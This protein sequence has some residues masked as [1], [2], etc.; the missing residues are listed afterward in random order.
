MKKVIFI[1]R[2]FLQFLIFES[3]HGG[4]E[5]KMNVEVDVMQ[6]LKSP[7]GSLLSPEVL[8]KRFQSRN[9]LRK[10]KKKRTNWM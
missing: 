8:I 3:K 2:R 10:K 7:S 5:K 9:P 1:L 6:N 4:L